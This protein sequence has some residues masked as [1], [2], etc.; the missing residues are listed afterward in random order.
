MLHRVITLVTPNA[1]IWDQ[2]PVCHFAQ[3]IKKALYSEQWLWLGEGARE[4]PGL[5]KMSH[6]LIGVWLLY[7]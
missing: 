1:V 3:A 4:P 2:M 6:T 5:M 7:R